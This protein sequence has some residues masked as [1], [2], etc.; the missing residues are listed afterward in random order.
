MADESAV[1]RRKHTRGAKCLEQC[2]GKAHS[3]GTLLGQRDVRSDMQP[4][5][6]NAPRQNDSSTAFGRRRCCSV[7]VGNGRRLGRDTLAPR[8]VRAVPEAAQKRCSSGWALHE[9]AI[10]YRGADDGGSTARCL[11]RECSPT[12]RD[13][14]ATRCLRYSTYPR[15]YARVLGRASWFGGNGA[16]RGHPSHRGWTMD[17]CCESRGPRFL[18]IRM[19]SCG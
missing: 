2:A 14:A 15:L 4:Q 10:P 16:P 19:S 11:P 18:R 17:A 9:R 5:M 3:A 7:C 6:V 13:P 1:G 12:W 8:A